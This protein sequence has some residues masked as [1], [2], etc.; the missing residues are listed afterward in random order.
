MKRKVLYKEDE[1]L[2]IAEQT[3]TLNTFRCNGLI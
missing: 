1:E 2:V 3:E